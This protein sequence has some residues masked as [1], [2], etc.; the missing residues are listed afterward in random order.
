MIRWIRTSRLP[1][2]NSL[3]L[4]LG[5]FGIEDDLCLEVHLL[6]FREELLHGLLLLFG[7]SQLQVDLRCGVWGWS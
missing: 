3:S 4:H 2:K 7:K 6:R 5:R 1:I